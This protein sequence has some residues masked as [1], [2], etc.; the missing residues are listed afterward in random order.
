MK[1]P[2]DF[3]SRLEGLELKRGVGKRFWLPSVQGKGC[4]PNGSWPKLQFQK[5]ENFTKGPR[6]EFEL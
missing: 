5:W 3:G 2:N 6:L 1:I 4:Y